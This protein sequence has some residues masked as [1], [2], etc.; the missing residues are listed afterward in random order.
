MNTPHIFDEFLPRD[1]RKTPLDNEIQRLVLKLRGDPRYMRLQQLKRM[2][3][4]YLALPI[5]PLPTPE[6]D[7]GSTQNLGH[8]GLETKGGICRTNRYRWISFGVY[9]A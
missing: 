2:Q 9:G 8:S 5:A 1:G 4:E 3:D 6:N 7:G